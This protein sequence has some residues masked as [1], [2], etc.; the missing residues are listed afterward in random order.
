MMSESG[1]GRD[2]AKKT[3]PV[4]GCVIASGGYETG[5]VTYCCEECASGEPCSNCGCECGGAK[6]APAKPKRKS[7]K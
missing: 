6:K 1:E 7:G 2:M 3:C 4:C 5:G